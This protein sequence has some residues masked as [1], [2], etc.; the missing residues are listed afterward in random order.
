MWNASLSL[1]VFLLSSA[2]HS[3]SSPYPP[4]CPAQVTQVTGFL[5][6]LW[7]LWFLCSTLRALPR[8]PKEKERKENSD[9]HFRATEEVGEA[10]SVLPHVASPHLHAHFCPFATKQ[11]GKKCVLCLLHVWLAP[12]FCFLDK[13]FLFSSEVVGWLRWWEN[14]KQNHPQWKWVS[15]AFS[16]VLTLE[17]AGFGGG[18]CWCWGTDEIVRRGTNMKCQFVHIFSQ[19]PC[20]V[21]VGFCA[22][23]MKGKT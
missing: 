3:T 1:A 12:F 11:L 17:T 8:S 10:G 16:G 2:P 5:L 4:F 6:L 20:K 14:W 15:P 22:T 21:G 19:N 23:G 9:N 13:S 18:G 7:A